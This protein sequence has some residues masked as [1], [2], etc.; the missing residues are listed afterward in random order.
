MRVCSRGLLHV[1]M[2]RETGGHRTGA[3]WV[4]VAAQSG[5]DRAQC[6]R[7][8]CPLRRRA[9]GNRSRVEAV[10]RTVP[11]YAGG[12]G[13]PRSSGT[14]GSGARNSAAISGGRSRPRRRAVRTMLAST[15]WVSAPWRV[16]LPPHTLR[17]TTAGRMACSA[18]QLVASSD[19]S[20][21]KRN[22][23][24]NSL[25][26]C[27]AKR[28]AS[29][30]RGGASTSR[31]RRAVSRPRPLPSRARSA[32]PRCSGRAGRGRP[33]GPP[34]PR[35]PRDCRDDPPGGAC[36]VG[37]SDSDTFGA[38]R[39]SSDTVPTRRA[40]ARRR[41]RSPAPWPHRRTRGRGRS[42]TPSCPR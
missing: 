42:R 21:R 16:R 15:C 14:T 10:I 3:H 7:R 32:L 20:H 38:V 36:S 25:A 35:R 28:S 26:R 5:G 39:R 40:R 17:M 27:A 31:P 34:A 19:G 37:A 29:S 41:S 23:A 24:G 8:L 13:R 12:G 9:A 1:A 22:T 18:R 6:G 2:A 30:S 11:A 4:G 33:A